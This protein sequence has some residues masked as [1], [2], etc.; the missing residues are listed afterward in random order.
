MNDLERI[1]F[2]RKEILRHNDLYYNNDDPEISDRE[3]DMLLRELEEL[4]KAH[5]EAYSED[6][7]TRRV[8]GTRNSSFEPV[9]HRVQLG[10]LQDVFSHEE[11]I[12]F[13]NRV[14]ESL[15]SAPLF[16]VE[17][18]I[19]GLSVALEYENGRFIRG[20]TR[21]DGFV[22][23]DVTENLRTIGSIPKKLPDSLPRLIVR[24]EVYMPRKAFER[25]TEESE[26]NGGKVF[27]NPRN[28]A[29]GSLRQ[30]D[31]RVTAA[32]GL[33][34]LIFNIQ[35]AEGREFVSHR[36][37]LEYLRSQ[38]FTVIDDSAAGD[39][40]DIV[41]L[42]EKIGENRDSYAYDIDGAVIKTDSLSQREE[43][44]STS[45]FPKWAVAYKYPPE[46]KE[47]TLLSVEVNVGRTGALTPTAVFEPVE[48]A[49]TTVSRAVLHN[50]DFITAKDIRIGDRIVVRKAGEIIPEV[51]R[52][53]SHKD[54]SEAYV[55]PDC[56]PVCGAKAV[57]DED[58]AVLRCPN[59]ECPAQLERNL[60]H[61]ASK[62]AMDIEGM[63]PAIVGALI[64]TGKL[65]NPAD[66]YSLEKEDI[67]GLE[68]MGEKSADNILKAVEKSRSRP[69]NRVIYGIGIRNI[70]TAS[71]KL[72]CDRFGSIEKIMAASEEDIAS[73]DGFGEV[74][75]RSVYAAF[76][77]EHFADLI[78]R[79]KAAGLT[80]G[81]ES[82]V[83]SDTFAGKTFVLTGTLPTLKR[84][85][86]QG[87]IEA[88]GGKV[89]G[90][91]SKK[92]D[93]VVAGEDA[94][95]KLTKAQTLGV[96]IISEEELLEMLNG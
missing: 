71:A 75:S 27:K 83:K 30:K 22:G 21:G 20:A 64:R 58:E 54:G 34:I 59:V 67:S 12:A 40:K 28:A 79:L 41:R 6:S 70:G 32:R 29:A 31:S 48:L 94:G 47:T 55:L 5:P 33:D 52:S 44:G 68:G 9:T 76:R 96:S 15:S 26:A 66:I 84:S 23:E 65:S 57:R 50:Q 36:E 51:L 53:V 45:K 39:D 82:S 86:A 90:S 38:G 60:I 3:Y 19:D 7:P 1:E 73:V 8:G 91:V 74:L 85:E 2:L 63:G 37:S 92:T 87:M 13:T 42:I 35:Y 80:M 72:L 18:K 17:P 78:Q 16:T 24:G 81:Y 56:C 62:D 93:F 88:A 14:R 89:S 77:D 95:S 11:V 69:L 61:F 4:E 49:G 43:L 25:L 10:S 46:E